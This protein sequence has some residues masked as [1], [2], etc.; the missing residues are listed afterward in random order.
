VISNQDEASSSE[1]EK[2]S[3]KEDKASNPISSQSASQIFS[4]LTPVIKVV[5]KSESKDSAGI[6]VNEEKQVEIRKP[7]ELN[8]TDINPNG[9]VTILFSEKLQSIEDLSKRG[10]NLT[11]FNLLKS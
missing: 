10:M 5:S 7:I 4:Y 2:E 3:K 8:I 11:V 1:V 6:V 9:E